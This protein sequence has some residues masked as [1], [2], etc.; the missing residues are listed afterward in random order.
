MLRTTLIAAAI[1][2]VTAAAQAADVQASAS[3]SASV[4]NPVDLQAAKDAA[5]KAAAGSRDAAINA[6]VGAMISGKSSAEALKA[7]S[8]DAKTAGMASMEQTKADAA[9]RMGTA[10]AMAA[11]YKQKTADMIS[12][13]D[14]L[15]LGKHFAASKAT[16]FAISKMF[17]AS[18][19]SNLPKDYAK[20]LVIGAKLDAAFAGK[21]TPIDATTVK[22]LSAQ[23]AGTVLVKV[24]D[25][26]VRLDAKTQV[27]LDV[28][29][30]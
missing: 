21:T 26:T 14:Q 19:N 22:G 20:K 6:G 27:V 5:A 17:G 10:Q 4:S 9:A 7:A 8:A 15:A 29:S 24:G 1:L 11:G 25:R 18:S 16:G 3:A 2:S 28:T 13:K 30:I 12:P 23:P